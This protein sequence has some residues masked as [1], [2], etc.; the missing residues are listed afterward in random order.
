MSA[1]PSAPIR[2]FGWLVGLP[3]LAAILGVAVPLVTPPLEARLDAEAG[4][5][6]RGTARA[7]A[8]PWLRVTAR[9]RDLVILG[10]APD[11]AAR[12][13]ALARLAALPGLRRIDGTLGL[14]E[15][16]APFVWTA[17]RTGPDRI[18]LTGNRPAEIGP[19]ALADRLA[20]ALP[21]GT[22]LDDTAHAAYGAPAEFGPAAAEAVS[23]LKALQPG[24]RAELADTRLSI[25]GEAISTEDEA[26]L[27]AALATPPAGFS[28][29][30]IEILP[31]K[32]PDFSFGLV[33]ATGGA[34]T[35]T[36]HVVSE[37]ARAA[38]RARAA[39]I[40]EGAGIL[41]ETH[42]ARGLDAR[43]D[44]AGLTAFA[45]RLV[46][47]LQEGGVTFAHGAMAVTGIAL[48]PQAV[49]EIAALL[50]DGRPA[51][52]EAGPATLE[53]RP[54][55]P[56]RVQ[57]RRE[58][59]SVTLGGHVPDAATRDRILAALRPRFFRERIIDRSRVAEGAPDGL[60]GALE[61]GI[62]T[63]AVLA[64]GEVRVADRALTLTGD[65]LYPESARR[66]EADL[67]RALPAG[68]RGEAAIAVP[69][70]ATGP[71]PEACAARFTELEP[72]QA[73]RFVPGSATPTAAFYPF[74]DTV[75]A[76]AKAC[77]TG[78]IAVT[79]HADPAGAAAPKPVLDSAVESTASVDA[80]GTDAKA[81]AKPGKTKPEAAKSEAAKPEATKPA[82]AADG[83][84]APDKTPAKADA[85]AEPEP[86]LPRQRALALVD[87]LL[88]A[89]LPPD[90]VT[91]DPATQARPPAEGI[92][93][94]LRP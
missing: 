56:Y 82:K 57:L 16:A 14:V 43:I 94:A 80:K 22:R 51:G 29:G 21:A 8:E 34:L 46:A 78:R 65:S 49:D 77:P 81:P 2:R 36:G 33:R 86:D 70:V 10:E 45:L 35:L 7:G 25:H 18:A 61:A 31:A 39:E 30:T 66:I 12:D 58:A 23:A 42:T 6:V 64:R 73:L 63:L 71:A 11:A 4:A 52:V 85:P 47:L 13:D 62:A 32:V 19:H 69:G 67:P 72:P 15:T 27:R 40:A 88:Q 84:A 75:A 26:R 41:D 50:R 60:T 74:L 79:G 89:G 48:D 83:K 59:D 37:T 76:W 53:T 1:S 90:R 9:G 24:A 55:K 68:W 5:V 44:P 93:L 38:L 87:Y 20:P 91:A 54:L 92:G 3:G 17:T 28:L